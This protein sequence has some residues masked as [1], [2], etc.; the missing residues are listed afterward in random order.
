VGRR[1]GIACTLPA[2]PVDWAPLRLV[3]AVVANAAVRLHLVAPVA[4][5][6]AE[7][8]EPYGDV[9]A[10]R[11]FRR[12]QR[13]WASLAARPGYG[14]PVL[15]QL[16]LD[17]FESIAGAQHVLEQDPIAI[18]DAAINPDDVGE[19]ET[20]SRRDSSDKRSGATIASTST[21]G[22]S[23]RRI[24]ASAKNWQSGVHRRSRDDFVGP[25]TG[26]STELNVRYG[27]R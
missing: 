6:Q 7:P 21:V 24:G 26:W 20:Q 2:G 1:A 19:E 12:Q 11:P 10:K 14:R 16:H 13:V 27:S 4:L 17:L 8:R 9:A 18:G 3:A 23:L 5:S 22:S 25:R 15:G